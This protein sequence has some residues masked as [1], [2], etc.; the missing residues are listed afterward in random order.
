MKNLKTKSFLLILS[1]TLFSFT[2]AGC[3]SDDD[4]NDVITDEPGKIPG[5]GETPGD[6]SGTPFTLPDGVVLEGEITG[7]YSFYS[8]SSSSYIPLEIKNVFQQK[9]LDVVSLKSEFADNSAADTIGSGHYVSTIINLKNSTASEKEI[10]FPAGLI[11]TSVTGNYQN[12][13]LLKKAST[14]IPANSSRK[15]RL[16][17]YCGNSDRKSSSPNETYRFAVVSNSSLIVDLCQRLKN[18][19]INIEEYNMR[20]SSENDV[21]QEIVTRL[22]SILWYLTDFGYSLTESEIEYIESLPNSK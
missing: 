18:K 22:Q 2:F 19:K 5:L 1:F 3:S 16:H 8:Y 6:L 14:K 12:G 10:V 21:H 4:D 15:I 13:V 11:L 20:N 17:M 9:N 7:A